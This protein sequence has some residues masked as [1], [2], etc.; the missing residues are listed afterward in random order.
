MITNEAALIVLTIFVATGVGT[1]LSHAV[2]NLI[3]RLVS[4][5]KRYV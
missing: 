4:R 2:N 1:M 5:R 3:K